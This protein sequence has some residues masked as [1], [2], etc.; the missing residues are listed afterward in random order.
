MHYSVKYQEEQIQ[1]SPNEIKEE[2][3]A[4]IFPLGIGAEFALSDR[5]LLDISLG[6]AFTSTTNLNNFN[7]GNNTIDTYII[8][9]LV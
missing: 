8:W 3:W 4:G 6:G 7:S 2:A 9:G 5:V 1:V